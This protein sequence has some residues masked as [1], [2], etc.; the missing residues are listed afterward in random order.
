[1]DVP[2]SDW[3]IHPSYFIYQGVNEEILGVIAYDA[4]QIGTSVTDMTRGSHGNVDRSNEQ[5]NW[6]L[7]AGNRVRNERR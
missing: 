6:K 1:M 5:C 2:Q 3:I 7:D 4:T